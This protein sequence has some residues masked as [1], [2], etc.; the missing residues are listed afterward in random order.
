[1]PTADLSVVVA[2]YNHAAK[3]PRALDAILSQSVRPREVVVLDDAS[4]R[5]DSR[6]VVEE[7]ARRDAAVKPV[8][9]A[10]NQGVC[11]TYNEGLATAVGEYVV[12]AAADD[13]VLP[14]FFEKL[15]TQLERHPDCGIACAHG[16]YRVGDGPVGVVPHAWPERAGYYTPDEVWAAVR[17]GI[18]GHANVCRRKRLAEVGGL[19]PELAWYSDWLAWLL[20]AFRGGC[21][22]VPETLSVTILQPESYSGAGFRDRTRNVAALASLLDR[23]TSPDAADVAPYFRRNGSIAFLGADLIRAAAGRPDC[24]SKP[25]LGLLN[26]FTRDDYRG[27]LDDPD[28]VVRELAAFFLGPFWQDTEREKAERDAELVHLRNLLVR[29]ESEALPPGIGGKL[30]W[31][32]GRAA[33]RLAG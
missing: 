20:I 23:L 28:P 5:D 9:H 11:A 6:A 13:Y 12:L 22:Y 21:C 25:V 14:G 27:L 24:W 2:N 3:L 17:R 29:A 7:Y 15:L 19:C 32:A 10:R 8:F 16:A 33:R 30:R 4:D 1:M 18:P 31:L 26:G